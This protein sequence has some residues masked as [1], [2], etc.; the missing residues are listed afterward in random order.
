M[1]DKYMNIIS[2]YLVFFGG[3]NFLPCDHIM[4][5]IMQFMFFSHYY[6]WLLQIFT[7]ILYIAGNIFYCVGLQFT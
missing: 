2:K 3:V 4:F 7:K 6:M 5:F 1:Q